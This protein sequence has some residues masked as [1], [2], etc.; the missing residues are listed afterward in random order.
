VNAED[1]DD[2]QREMWAALGQE[3][4]DVDRSDKIAEFGSP[5]RR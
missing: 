2:I 4:L 1:I 3:S 5:W